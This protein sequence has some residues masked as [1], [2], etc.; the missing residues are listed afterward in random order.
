MVGRDHRLGTTM[1]IGVSRRRRRLRARTAAALL[2]LA[3]TTAGPYPVSAGATEWADE[4]VLVTANVDPSSFSFQDP[5][6]AA[7]LEMDAGVWRVR[8]THQLSGRN[9]SA[10]AF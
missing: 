10:P 2:T 7:W 6:I 3:A 8:A 4:L 9:W 5:G 1:T